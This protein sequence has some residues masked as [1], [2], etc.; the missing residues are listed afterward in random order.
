MQFKLRAVAN[1]HAKNKA[2]RVRS[3]ILMDGP[4]E[5]TLGRRPAQVQGLWVM[6]EVLM[7]DFDWPMRDATAGRCRFAESL[8]AKKSG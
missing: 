6:V 3:R 1:E 2:G 7:Q 4:Y 8:S 5:V